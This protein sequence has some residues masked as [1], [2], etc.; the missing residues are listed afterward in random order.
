MSDKKAIRE[1]KR[2]NRKISATACS[3]CSL[4]A[5]KAHDCLNAAETAPQTFRTTST[6]AMDVSCN[7]KTF[8]DE[9]QNEPLVEL[10]LGISAVLTPADVVSKLAPGILVC[11]AVVLEYCKINKDFSSTF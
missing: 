2:Y 6:V 4:D 3:F 5:V 8:V 7:K 1:W 10:A 11:F 9:S